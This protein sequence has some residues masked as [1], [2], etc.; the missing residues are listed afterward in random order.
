MGEP[1]PTVTW[2]TASPVYSIAISSDNSRIA[3]GSR[4][5]S[6][7]VWDTKTGN[8]IL[9]SLQ[10][11]SQGVRSVAFSPDDSV[12][13]SGS[14]DHTVGIWDA[15]SGAPVC[16]FP[17]HAG[18]VYSVSFSPDGS[19]I[20]SGSEDRTVGIWQSDNGTPIGNRLTGHF[21]P[22]TSVSVSRDG[23]R[24]VS[25]SQDTTIRIWDAYTK[26]LVA[27]PLYGHASK[28]NSVAF[29][30]DDTRIVSCSDD[31]TI[32]LWDAHSG[33]PVG[34]PINGHNNKVYSV[35][36]SPDNKFIVSGS[37]DQ[38]I[39]LW[40]V[41]TSNPVGEPLMGHTRAVNSVSFSSDCIRIVSG[42]WDCTVRVWN[43][44]HT[45]R[46]AP[47][48][49]VEMV[50]SKMT[51]QEMFDCLVL[52]G[53]T[54]LTSLMNPDRYSTAA[55]VNGG[56]GD[57]WQ[58]VM[59][60]G[61]MVAIKSLRL[62]M[63]LEGD[64]KGMKRAMREIYIWRKA[65]HE[66]VQELTG[67]VMF[68][69][70]LGM[71]SPWMENGNLQKYLEKNLDVERYPLC[72]QL[73][74]GVSYLHSIGMVHGDLKAANVLVS[75]EGVLKISDFDHAIL[76][77]TTLRFS[78]TTNVGGGTLRWMAPELIQQEDDDPDSK[79]PV[80]RNKQTDV[81]ALGMTMLE[82][83]SGAVPYAEYRSDMGIYRAIDRKQLP[84]RPKLPAGPDEPANQ[85]WA[86]LVRCWD[87]DPDDR[88]EA[89]FVLRFLQLFV[90]HTTPS[91]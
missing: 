14:E 67:I 52:H 43:M 79:P 5:Y 46:V 12:I 7:S 42:S 57:V 81:Y 36:F 78:K 17:R 59:I 53:C 48:R 88:P 73:A 60:D 87:H 28:I 35:A 74:T 40:D 2:D 18:G 84:K 69:G 38:T 25:S 39:R 30:F 9:K 55:I 11:H 86:L 21:G 20:V 4:D 6:V 29:S 72:V 3:L 75:Q 70:G 68:Q 34:E 89:S 80:A 85:M 83:V 24:I 90:L 27:G 8:V 31:Y 44:Q 26:A 63:I 19:Y 23:T 37:G 64:E 13:V 50:S 58:G 56:F 15:N 76:P 33:A 54:D 82:I 45:S 49:S 77:D 91:S 10:K 41:N 66:N 1:L 61:K 65:K 51:A 32:R 16:P 22:I 62:H 71:V 47:S